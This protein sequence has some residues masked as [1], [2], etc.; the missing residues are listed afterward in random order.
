MNRLRIYI[1]RGRN[2]NGTTQKRCERKT[3]MK[4]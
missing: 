2:I 3:V 1:R 4:Q